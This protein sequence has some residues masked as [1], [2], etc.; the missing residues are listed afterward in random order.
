[1]TSPRVLRA[2]LWFLVIF[3]IGVMLGVTFIGASHHSHAV[4]EA[5]ASAHAPS[6]A[7]EAWFETHRYGWLVWRIVLLV[8]IICSWPWVMRWLGQ[9]RTWHPDQIA[10]AVGYRGRVASYIIA[11]ELVIGQGLPLSLFR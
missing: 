5:L 1:M 7:L 9:R 6:R 8:A 3:A 10:V 4:V 2:L 11:V